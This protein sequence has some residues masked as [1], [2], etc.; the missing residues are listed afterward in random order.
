M[1][2]PVTIPR[3]LLL[4]LCTY[5]HVCG[6]SVSGVL[7]TYHSIT[8][9]NN[10]TSKVTVDNAAG[11]SSGQRVMIYQAKGTTM[12]TT[13]GATYGNISSLN[14]AGGYEFNTI[15][16]ISGNEVWLKDVLVNAYDV[17]GQV[18]LVTIP[19]Y[20]S[21]VI[22]GT[23]TA[24]PW[25][26]VTGK[27]GI[28]V[29]EASGTITLNA[30]IDVSGQGFQGGALV[31]YPTPTWDCGP[32]DNVN[33]YVLPI[34]ASGNTTAGKKGEGI[35]AYTPGLEYA[36]GKLV[37]GGGGGNNANSGG[38]GGG[39]YGA[40]GIGGKRA[41][42]SLGSCHGQY[43]GVGGASLAAYG[44]SAGTN[45]LFFGGGGGSGH[46]NNAVG[47]PGGNGGGMIILTATSIAGG[48]GRLLASG[49][50][51]VNP[52]NGNPVEAEGD[53]AG[54]GGAGGVIILNVSSVSGAITAEAKGGA[55]SNSSNNVN[56][57]TGPGGG[58]GGGL[59]WA[60]GGSFPAAVTAVVDG[61][62]SGV[63]SANNTK[64]S[65]KGLANGALPGGIGDKLPGYVAPVSPG[66]GCTVLA[67][68]ELKYF[69]AKGAGQDV[70]LSWALVSPASAADIR[71]FGIERS[72]DNISFMVVGEVSASVDSVSYRFVD[73]VGQT[74]GDVYY[75][76]TW[77][78]SNGDVSYSR[79]I[80]V[81]RKP[82]PPAFSFRIQP[83]PVT[84]RCT[85]TMM[86]DHDGVAVASV[87]NAQ[88]RAL[89]RFGM[90]LHKG[91]NMVPLS[92]G[93]LNAG[94]YFLSVDV[95]GRRQVRP[96][97]RKH[98]M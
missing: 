63:V 52:T 48:G 60:A 35:A 86:M 17:S 84:D 39:N 62:I 91:E 13:N 23:V 22:A 1:K 89:Q 14:S 9:V 94:A 71:S 37:N 10:A 44:Y 85:L 11:L 76:L 49:T 58:G 33:Q 65:C 54:G 57:C 15:C 77:R 36:R 79:I 92:F 80:S 25:D 3:L 68:S 50:N 90:T 5:S 34:P 70:L 27:G 81:S 93:T 18:Q 74:E 21:V 95:D 43:P 16:S 32:L 96:F 64:A 47:T 29:I 97:I 6:Q 87:Y 12:V 55:G 75:R 26:P 46:E 8:A 51:P 78:H 72:L 38:G 98:S 2:T 67:V 28:V 7:N 45:R 4:I 61:G 88:G 73:A 66:P 53:G 69:M 19:S 41:G 30:D 24:A 42:E 56:D 82:A 40:G 31:N 59:V 83:N 20:S